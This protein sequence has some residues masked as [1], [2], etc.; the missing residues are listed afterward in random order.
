MLVP[1]MHLNYLKLEEENN[2]LM[3]AFNRVPTFLMFSPFF[4]SFVAMLVQW[5]NHC[6]PR[7]IPIKQDIVC[8]AF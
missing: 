2:W 6:L 4:S 8:E 3:S 5:D 7:L 1:K